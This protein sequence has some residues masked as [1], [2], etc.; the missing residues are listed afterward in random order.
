VID[1]GFASIVT[2]MFGE[3]EKVSLIP[4]KARR[5]AGKTEEKEF[6]HLCR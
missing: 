4:E 1:A 6:L 5:E 2:S 3:I